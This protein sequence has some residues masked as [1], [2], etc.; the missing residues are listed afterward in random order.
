MFRA[1]HTPPLRTMLDDLLTRDKSAISKHLDV[2]PVTLARWTAADQA[3]R[4]AMLAL[5]YETRWGRSQLFTDAYNAET[6]ARQ[7]CAGLMRENAALRVRIARL[8]RL[9]S[10]GDGFGSANEPMLMQR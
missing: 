4:P 3:P 7:E 2:S 5:F 6:Y 10:A 1:S 8:E 9:G